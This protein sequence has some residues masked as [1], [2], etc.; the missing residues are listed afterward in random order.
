MKRFK[1]GAYTVNVYNAK[2][3]GYL[4]VV[5]HGRQEVYT[6]W[7]YGFDDTLALARAWIRTQGGK[8]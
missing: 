1:Y 7:D 5:L 6:A 3:G 8:A 2:S 4:A